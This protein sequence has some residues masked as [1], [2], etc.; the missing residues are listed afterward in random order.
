MKQ[1]ITVLQHDSKDEQKLLKKWKR[2]KTAE[3]AKKI[4]ID[5]FSGMVHGIAMYGKMAPCVFL[6]VPVHQNVLDHYTKNT[7]KSNFR[8]K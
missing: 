3:K 1:K 6:A 8:L 2:E 5:V 7:M 4:A